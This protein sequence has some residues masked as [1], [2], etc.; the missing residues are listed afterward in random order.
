MA[1]AGGEP[2]GK[3][4]PFARCQLRKESVVVVQGPGGVDG[5]ALPLVAANASLPQQLLV[6]LIVKCFG[7]KAR[8]LL[9]SAA[10]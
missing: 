3:L 1:Q 5:D 9:H 7:C 8:L 6:Q 10:S 2:A 4:A